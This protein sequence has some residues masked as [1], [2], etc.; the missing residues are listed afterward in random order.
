M[1][2]GL[3]KRKG[4]TIQEQICD[5]LENNNRPSGLGNLVG[6]FISI[7]IGMATLELVFRSLKSAELI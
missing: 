5:S 3:R 4:K 7:A 1:W 2:Q 6:A